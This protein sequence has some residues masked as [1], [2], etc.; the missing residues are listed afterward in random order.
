MTWMVAPQVVGVPFRG[1]IALFYAAFILDTDVSFFA[2]AAFVGLKERGNCGETDTSGT[3][4]VSARCPA[5]DQDVVRAPEPRRDR[6]DLRPG[7]QLLPRLA[8]D[9]L[10][11]RRLRVPRVPL[12]V[13]HLGLR[14]RT[15]AAPARTSPMAP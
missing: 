12:L 1:K 6:P 8:G 11:R 9:E 14:H 7:P 2:G 3:G 10:L 13:E 4:F 15:A 5:A